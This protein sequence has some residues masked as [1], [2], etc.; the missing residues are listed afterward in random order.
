MSK[1][2]GLA[3]ILL[4]KIA[5]PP[6][7]SA[8]EW[9]DEHRF[10]SAEASSEPGRWK[11]SRTPYLKLIL[12]CF[13][14]PKVK[15]IVFMAS[16][17]VGKTE[18]LLNAA[19]YHM[20]YD[21]CPILLV[22]PTDDM[23]EAFSKDRLSPMIRDTPKLKERIN[24]TKTGKKRGKK[25]QD[26]IL[27]KK[28]PG[29][30]ITMI[31]SNSPSKLAS[32]PIRV[33][34]LDE[35]D[36]F[37]ASAGEEGDPSK[38]AEKRTK[39]FWNKKI[40]MVSTP[41]IKGS[42]KIEKE[43]EL[44]NKHEYYIPCMHCG[45]FQTLKFK[46]IKWDKDKPETATYFCE[47]CGEAFDESKKISSLQNGEW[48]GE[49]SLSETMGFHINELYSPWV[50][51]KEI[52][53]EFLDA[54]KQG[55]EALKTWVNTSLGETWKEKEGDVPKWRELYARREI[56]TIGK[57]PKGAY[58][59]TAG[60]DVQKG[61]V[62][63]EVVG[64]G[65]NYESWS[66]EY[67]V[68]HV[69]TDDHRKLKET[70]EKIINREFVGEN[71]NSYKI[72]KLAVDTGYNT[73]ICY[74]S[75]RELGD[76]RVIA[77]KGFDNQMSAISLPRQVDVNYNGEKIRNG[78]RYYGVGSSLLKRQIYGY[79]RSQVPTEAEILENG[80]PSGFMHFPQYD[81]EYFKMLTAEV[82][83]SKRNKAGFTKYF[84]E[85]IRDRNEALDCRVYS[86]AA[87]E[88]L[89]Y[90]QW[91]ESKFEQ[92]AKLFQS[93]CAPKTKKVKKKKKKSNSF[94]DGF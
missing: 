14:N 72:A 55:T 21:P 79:L 41:T 81:E 57:V 69:N 4:K 44:S 17:Q 24:P 23:A 42:S 76:P 84:W 20:D 13:S 5:P 32:R 7:L 40:F 53:K 33:V 50:K 15:K 46:N 80:H 56:Y 70:L 30:H 28:F 6:R 26:N 39:T 88:S 31:G 83:K 43:F 93:P 19:G 67:K 1:A 25:T 65:K 75:I 54:K 58:F 82:L 10:L 78:M 18:C 22:Q 11:T 85:K 87:L 9:A 36:R 62:E 29:G 63:Y 2:Y 90:S 52:V 47:C 66:V 27:H 12:D 48:R 38:L 37:P 45:E 64:W 3:K 61:R 60:L 77:V 92:Y 59:L 86:I 91:K 8:S 34:L 89:T 74:N 51:F 49:E 35:V 94:L 16:A 71:F 73:Q 68:E